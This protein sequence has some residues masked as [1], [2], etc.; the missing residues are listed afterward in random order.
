MS[1]ALQRDKIAD[2][3]CQMTDQIEA[4]LS[5]IPYDKLNVSEEVQEQVLL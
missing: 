4:S 5:S 1:Q 3:F 2:K